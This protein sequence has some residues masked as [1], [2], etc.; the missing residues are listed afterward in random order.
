MA[1]VDINGLEFNVRDGVFIAGD[2][3]RIIERLDE[4]T[5]TTIEPGQ[6]NNTCNYNQKE[7]THYQLRKQE[8]K[9][10]GGNTMVETLTRYFKK[11]EDF[12]MTLGVIFLMD[13][14]VF[15]GMFLDRLKG[16][17]DGMLKRLEKKGV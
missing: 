17:V 10:K 16:I 11:N 6:V 3:F 12:Y 15:N 4:S 2:Q 13:H 5:L 1:L 7:I 8:V 14:F 9:I